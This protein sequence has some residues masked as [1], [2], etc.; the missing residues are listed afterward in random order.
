MIEGG[1]KDNQI[2]QL[3]DLSK[4][5]LDIRDQLN[6]IEN[7]LENRNPSEIL[8][9]IQKRSGNI[10]ERLGEIRERLGKLEGKMHV[11]LIVLTIIG[12]L[13]AAILSKI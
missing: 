12:G 8:L 10:E 7:K 9:D 2:Q 11:I 1:K 3:Q 5:L 4:T 6:R 13:L